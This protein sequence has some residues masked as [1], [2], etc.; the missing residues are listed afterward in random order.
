M[1]L[2]PVG[3]AFPDGVIWSVISSVSCL[4]NN[5]FQAVPVG[6]FPRFHFPFML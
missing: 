2:S 5:L 4:L 6:R 1:I 3:S